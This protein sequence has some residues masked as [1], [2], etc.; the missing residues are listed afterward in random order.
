ML[1]DKQR[2]PGPS[3]RRR[4]L[5]FV[6]DDQRA[7]EDRIATEEPLEIR[8][9]APGVA[10]VTAWVTMRTPGNDFDL[11]AGWA[12]H[13][14]VAGRGDITSIAY[15]T[16]AD[17]TAEQEFNVVTMT[18]AKAP[19]L[20]LRTMTAA[21]GSS[22]CG[23]CGKDSIA[24]VLSAATGPA[25]PAERPAADVVRR[26]PDALRGRQLLFDRTGGVHAAA[27]TTATGE[28]LVARE[29]IGR[30]NAVD[31]GVGARVLAGHPPAAAALVVSG[32]AGF[33]LVQ[34][35]VVSGTGALVSVGAPTSLAV[36]LAE[37]VGLN[38]WGFTSPDRVIRY[39]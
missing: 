7:R 12:I 28:V 30:H 13:E 33:E 38:L 10:P 34:K 32:R 26:L 19:R 36:E 6:G 16:N 29:D 2:R 35:A 3:V 23:V 5:E 39:C 11:A 8:V 24:S 1:S 4:V 21:S 17:L 14:S 22:A 37:R 20:P 9:V 15:C 25:W 31:K 27:L 18:L